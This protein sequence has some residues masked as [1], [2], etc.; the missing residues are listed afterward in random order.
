MQ[1]ENKALGGK[2]PNAG[3]DYDYGIISVKRQDV[4]YEMPMAPITMMRNA[5][6]K[7]FGGSGVKLDLKKYK[8]SVEFW[9]KHAMIQ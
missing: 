8:K 6:G 3:K 9:N 7:E 1:E 2:D 5:L 4:D